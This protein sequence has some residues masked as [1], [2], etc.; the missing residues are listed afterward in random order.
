MRRGRFPLRSD[1]KPLRPLTPIFPSDKQTGS[2]VVGNTPAGSLGPDPDLVLV[3]DTTLSTG[4]E[5]GIRLFDPDLLTI[6]WGDGNTEPAVSTGTYTHTYASEGTYTVRV[7]AD[8]PGGTDL[9]GFNGANTITQ[10]EKLTAVTSWGSLGITSLSLACWNADNVTAVADIPAS[11]TDTSFMF[12]GAIGFTADLSGLSMSAVE[13]IDG[14]FS[15]ASSFNQDIGSWDVSSVT[16]MVSVFLQASSF[17]QDIGSWDV[18]S[19]TDMTGMFRL[20]SSFNQDLS[21]WCV[22]LIGSKPTLFDS[23]ASAWVLPQPVW[24]TCP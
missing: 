10:A 9:G 15:Q 14:M 21:G 17:D 13:T 1:G 20:A 22:S 19:V 8:S 6:D 11:V 3:Y 4:T 12:Q 7:S 5:V 24:G 16:S 18:S 2:V 23:G